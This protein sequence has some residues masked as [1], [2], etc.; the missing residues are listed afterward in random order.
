MNFTACDAFDDLFKK[1]KPDTSLGG[2]NNPNKDPN[3]TE[4]PP[5][6]TPEVYNI[7]YV[8]NG[9]TLIDDVSNYTEGEGVTLPVSI[10]RQYYIF[11]GWYAD[12]DFSGSVVTEILKTDK[13]NKTYY[14][15]WRGETYSVSLYIDNVKYSGADCITS[16]TYNTHTHLPVPQKSGYTFDGWYTDL[17]CTQGKTDE[18]SINENGNKKYYAKWIKNGQVV[19][20]PEV[21]SINFVTNGGTLDGAPDSYTEGEEVTLPVT[22]SKQYYVFEG[23]YADSEFDG[24]AVTKILSTDKGNKTYYAKW[25]GETYSV[26]LYI[27]NTKYTGT[28]NVTS[29]TYNTQT[30]LP[31]PEKSGYTFDGWYSDIDCTQNKTNK[32]SVADNGNK[33][34]YAKWVKSIVNELALSSYGGYEEGAYVE[35]STLNGVSN[36]IVEYKSKS[37]SDSKYVKID[38]Q[39]IR[40]NNDIV[41]ADIVGISKG[42]YTI[43]VTAGS[44]SVTTDVNVA[45]YDRS[46]YAHFNIG[47]SDYKDGIGGYNADGTPKSGAYIIYV[48]EDTKN[49]VVCPWNS[50]IKGI[51][52]I[53]GNASK[54]TKP[55]IVRIIGTVGAATWNEKS[56][57]GQITPDILIEN[58]LGKDGAK[59][60]K[61]TYSQADLIKGGFNTLNTSVYAEL[62]GLS[63]QMRYDSSKKEFDSCWND[64]PI[65]GAK[66]VTVEGIGS[67]SKIFQ[68]GMTWKKCFSIEVRN[69]T[70][71]DYT[72]D[73]CSFE[74]GTDADNADNFD[75]QRIW[76]HNNTFC[77]GINYWDVCNE[78][79]KHDGDGSTDFKKCSYITIS[80]NH[81][82]KTHKTGLIGGGDTHMTANVTFHHNFYDTC[83][84]RLPLARQ[85]NMH[86]YNNYYYKTTSTCLSIRASGYA[87]VENCYFDN[88]KNPL[89]IK[90]GGVIKVF[91][92]EF[93]KTSYD[94]DKVVSDRTQK[95]ENTNAFGQDFDTNSQL[96]YYDSVNKKSNVERMDEVKDVPSVVKALAGVHHN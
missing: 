30:V 18:I 70:F 37:S 10:S 27:D 31:T 95:V 3:H 20:P 69:I 54:A 34:F 5:V 39:L 45:S 79:D 48:T 62:E 78:Q 17:N 36:Y 46:G 33:D 82:I 38:S 35:F 59:L 29:Y 68:W 87:F 65:S 4:N 26:N 61:K 52:G 42:D 49:T 14:A 64:C 92:C 8:T 71:D 73:A 66:N 50:K 21:Y 32:I 28:D 40:V 9:G 81:Y 55:V 53:L 19:T 85:A 77:E 76:V 11:E 63:S 83:K 58:T 80:Y 1:D 57:S 94:S 22:I 86:M 84:S 24:S 23:W 56:Y 7:T 44:V 13:G 90:S 47:K 96:F 12:S 41:R 75:S 43:K 91:K 93:I 25:R 15:K 2:E 88:A 72:E 51:V 67:D 74:G 16:Y 6:T 60:S 89:E